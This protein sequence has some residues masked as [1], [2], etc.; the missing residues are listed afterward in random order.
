MKILTHHYLIHQQAALYH[1]YGHHGGG[2][3]GSPPGFLHHAAGLGPGHSGQGPDETAPAPGGELANM[4]QSS[5]SSSKAA[6]GTG[7]GK[8]TRARKTGQ[9]HIYYYKELYN[10]CYI[11]QLSSVAPVPAKVP[12]DP[13]V[14]GD[15]ASPAAIPGQQA[16]GPP[17]AALLTPVNAPFSIPGASSV[18][19][20]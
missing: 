15:Q 16:G 1:H 11:W 20:Q 9:Q 7:G 5:G 17:G 2:N 3:N 4:P 8:S 19:M 14:P 13:G 6:A 12:G 10:T 18:I